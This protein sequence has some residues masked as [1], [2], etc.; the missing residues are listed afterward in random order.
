[1][2]VVETAAAF[3]SYASAKLD[4]NMRQ[5]ERCVALLDEPA[6][7]SRVN[8]KCNSVGNLLLHLTGNVRQWVLGGIAGQPVQRNRPA[9]FAQRAAQPAAPIVAELA[10]VVADA[11][12]V[13]LGL[14]SANLAARRTIQTYEVTVLVAVFHVVE[15]F[16]WHTGQIVHMT[17]ALRGVDLSLYDAEG[18]KPGEPNPFP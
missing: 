4:Q 6:I 8:E 10:G 16:S 2:T 7:W 9:E 18:H 13:I 3:T 17:K 1:M 5:I 15:H 14:S 11:R 12:N